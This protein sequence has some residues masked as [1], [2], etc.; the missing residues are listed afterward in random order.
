MCSKK[1][2]PSA[3]DVWKNDW[4]QIIRECRNENN[5]NPSKSSVICSIHFEENDLYTTKRGLLRVVAYTVPKKE[6]S[7]IVTPV[8]GVVSEQPVSV[9]YTLRERCMKKQLMKM[10][11]LMQKQKKKIKTLNQKVRRL[12]NRNKLLKDI[13]KNRKRRNYVDSAI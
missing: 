6:L 3:N 7:K 2:F 11:T 8:S 1:L 12:Q 9:L 13:L 5:W 4:V 10:H